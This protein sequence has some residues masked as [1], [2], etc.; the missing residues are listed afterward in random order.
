M[1]YINHP[2][3]YVMQHISFGPT[4]FTRV[5]PP[6]SAAIDF[7]SRRIWRVRQNLL[8]QVQNSAAHGTAGIFVQK[9]PFYDLLNKNKVFMKVE[10]FY[11]FIHP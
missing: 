9:F 5:E 10:I 1:V 11:C 6:S 4:P 2:A 7:A 3:V 8:K